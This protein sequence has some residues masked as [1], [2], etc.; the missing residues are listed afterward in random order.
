[1]ASETYNEGN[2]TSISTQL[3][4]KVGAFYNLFHPSFN[5]QLPYAFDT[6]E[7]RQEHEM[8]I[9]LIFKEMY[10]ID[11]VGPEIMNDID[12]ILHINGIMNPLNIKRGMI[13]YYPEYGNLQNYRLT[14]E[15]VKDT[16]R[17]KNANKNILLVPNKGK[18]KDPAREAYKNN[19]YSAPPT[20]QAIPREPVRIT[21]DGKFSIGGL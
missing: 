9:D 4:F 10:Q 1:M 16:S 21:S 14:D 20:A 19:G 13:L 2:I 3:K 11:V 5:S 12:V 6:F 7:V 8:R 15:F 17:N 18:T